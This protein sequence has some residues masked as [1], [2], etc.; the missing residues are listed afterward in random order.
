MITQ[1]EMPTTIK[2]D[3]N[4][5]MF[6][7]H[8]EQ[9]KTDV[10]KRRNHFARLVKNAEEQLDAALNDGFVLITQYSTNDSRGEC[11]VF[12]LHKNSATTAL[13]TAH[14]SDGLSEESNV[15]TTEDA[16]RFFAKFARLLKPDEDDEDDEDYEDEDD[17]AFF[18]DEDAYEDEVERLKTIVT[19]LGLNPYCDYTESDFDTYRNLLGTI[20]YRP[21]SK[22]ARTILDIYK[23]EKPTIADIVAYESLNDTPSDVISANPVKRV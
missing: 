18:A 7:Q 4:L 13:T 9:A 1:I 6:A 2:F 10:E 23:E 16:H 14:A 17:I 8:N 19:G 22:T 20:P 12:V 21:Y 11:I 3:S 15:L 5:L